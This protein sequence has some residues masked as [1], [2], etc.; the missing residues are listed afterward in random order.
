MIKNHHYPYTHH[1]IYHNEV[2]RYNDRWKKIFPKQYLEKNRANGRCWSDGE[3]FL[4]AFLAGHIAD[5]DKEI[6]LHYLKLANEFIQGHFQLVLNPEQE[7]SLEL[8]S[9]IIPV[10]GKHHK[11]YMQVHDFQVAFCLAALLRD[12]ESLM[13]LDRYQAENYIDPGVEDLPIDYPY[14]KFLK[15]IYQPTVDLQPLLQEI[16]TLSGPEHMPERRQSY[17]YKIMLSFIEIIVAVLENNKNK[18]E[19]AIISALESHIEHYS[20]NRRKDV[21]EGWVALPICAAAAMAYDKYGFKL[22]IISPYLPEWLI[23]KDFDD[24]Y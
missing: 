8:D 20:I 6:C 14:Y 11:L 24:I 23:Y 21:E 10:R 12:E 15:G 22:P 3:T 1:R 5:A 18:Y 16:V 13:L 9:Q 7:F 17:V 19:Q 4:R 2:E